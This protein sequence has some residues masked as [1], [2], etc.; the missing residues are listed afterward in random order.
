MEDKCIKEGLVELLTSF[1]DGNVI[2]ICPLAQGGSERR[3]YRI[4]T[5]G[6]SYIGTY[7][8][9]AAEGRCFV[10]L[11][12]D[13]RS[14]ECC[15]PA[16]LSASTDGHF[17][18][19]EDLGDTSLF[20]VLFSPER[21]KYVR[22]TLLR[23]VSLQQTPKELWINDCISKPF[24]HRQVMWDLNYFKYEYLKPQELA[25]DEDL[26]ED[27]FER[28]S[29]RL[30]SVP[31]RLCGFM[32]RDC[33]SRNVMLTERGPLFIDFQGGRLGPAL[34]D[35]V[36]LLWQAR[37]GFD[38]D[39]R[40]R[41]L[42]LYCDAF[43][44]GD[45]DLKVEMLSRLDDMLL[46]RNL[47]VLGAY[48][49]R[50]LVQHKSHFLLSIPAALNNLRELI[51]KRVLDPYPELKR[52]AVLLTA[53]SSFNMCMDYPGLTVEVFSFSYKKGYPLDLS[54]N[55]GGFMF[56]CRALHNPGRY[57]EYKS[58]TGCDRPVMEFLEKKGEIRGFLHNVWSL[59]DPAIERFLSRGFT[60]L[61]I[62]FGC[63]GGQ[64][65]SVYCAEH[66]AEHIN[67]MFPEVNVR[68]VHR[69]QENL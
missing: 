24:V 18:I 27:D 5:D 68:L 65:R 20:S 14:A 60:H 50:G 66:T 43:C 2:S 53:G 55:G 8:P 59:T 11:A 9:D 12:R 64:H 21:A 15:V 7:S 67:E 62:G 40:M 4:R 42:D 31:V 34:Y 69:E 23:L 37:A 46:F 32:M 28:F 58:L 47:Q 52:C 16:I 35:A 22:E 54:G 44:K 41:M 49:F 51:E 3:Y 38:N 63:T 26:L 13:L 45:V 30:A 29:A 19:Q 33:Q 61:Q 6:N 17:Y 48:G 36:S 1:D 56:D 10:A 39:F 57:A 25:F